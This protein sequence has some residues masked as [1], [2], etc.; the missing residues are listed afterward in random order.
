MEPTNISSPPQPP[1]PEPSK[2]ARRAWRRAAQRR[3]RRWRR[4]EFTLD[5]VV[6]GVLAT[7]V[8]LYLGAMALGLLLVLLGLLYVGVQAVLER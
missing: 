2:A 6:N 1:R 7:A 8:S 5:R 3:L 4:L